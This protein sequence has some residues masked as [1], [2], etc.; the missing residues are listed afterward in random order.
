MIHLHKQCLNIVP[1]KSW[2]YNAFVSMS[3]VSRLFA[4][5]SCWAAANPNLSCR[6]YA[7]GPSLTA[8]AGRIFQDI[9]TSTLGTFKKTS[10]KTERI[11]LWCSLSLSL[12]SH[13]LDFKFNLQK[14][15]KFKLKSEIAT[16]PESEFMSYGLS[17]LSLISFPSQ[18]APPNTKGPPQGKTHPEAE[19]NELGGAKG[20][21]QDLSRMDIRKKQKK[22][23][24]Y[25]SWLAIEWFNVLH[26]RILFVH[27]CTVLYVFF[28][29]NCNMYM[30]T[31]W[32]NV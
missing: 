7:S 18:H 14:S 27:T 32:Y 11:C 1:S 21:Q 24:V 31:F 23:E 26:I 15:I 28:L 30:F 17:L 16:L 12:S 20:Y 3:R 29:Y 22:H 25:V 9:S 8:S 10:A 13:E 5:W 4:Q 2:D 6:K 19:R